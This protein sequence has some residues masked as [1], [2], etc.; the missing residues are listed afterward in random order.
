MKKSKVD[1]IIKRKVAEAEA[2]GRDA[3]IAARTEGRKQ[4]REKYELLV[5]PPNDG[6]GVCFIGAKPE[7]HT[8]RV[9]LDPR[10]APRLADDFDPRCFR[11]QVANFSVKMQYQ[12][13]GNGQRVVWHEYQFRGLE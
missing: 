5:I 1:A 7:H 2:R 12:L 4:E 6:T 13:F 10:F 11:Q 3:A 8:V 9:P